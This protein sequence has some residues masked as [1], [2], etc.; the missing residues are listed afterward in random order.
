MVKCP[1]CGRDMDHRPKLRYYHCKNCDKFITE[2]QGR[3]L[4]EEERIARDRA[5]VEHREKIEGERAGW[6]LGKR[7]KFWLRG[8]VSGGKETVIEKGKHEKETV[9][10]RTEKIPKEFATAIAKKTK[11]KVTAGARRV[12]GAVGRTIDRE[13]IKPTTGL[14]TAAFFGMVAGP[15]FF[16]FFNMLLNVTFVTIPLFIPTIDTLAAVSG[17]PLMLSRSYNRMIAPQAERINQDWL[18]MEHWV[19]YMMVAF[20]V[21][22]WISMIEF[23]SYQLYQGKMI[24]GFIYTAS[25]GT[26]T[27]NRSIVI[28]TLIV[29]FT[30]YSMLTMNWALA[31]F[32]DIEYCPPEIPFCQTGEEVGTKT[33]PDRSLYIDTFSLEE[34]S[35]E[36]GRTLYGMI[37][38]TN[39][40]DEDGPTLKNV[41]L[42]VYESA[43]SNVTWESEYMCNE[44]DP[45]EIKP[46]DYRDVLVE[47]P[48]TI[49]E[50]KEW[51]RKDLVV[52]VR[53]D[54]I[55]ECTKQFYIYKS[56][57]YV[58]LRSPEHVRGSGPVNLKIIFY[59]NEYSVWFEKGGISKKNDMPILMALKFENKLQGRAYITEMNIT[60]TGKEEYLL[61]RP[62]DCEGLDTREIDD[63]KKFSIDVDINLKR[64]VQAFAGIPP[65]VKWI[66]CRFE[67][68]S[69]F[70]DRSTTLTF[71]GS[72]KYEYTEKK[73]TYTYVYSKEIEE[74]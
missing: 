33:G 22:P 53:Y 62:S 16:L 13:V 19:P 63:D 3:K 18:L 74:R 7:F 57:K 37:K 12:G 24:P 59:P 31:Q 66:S 35:V 49:R 40:N 58:T 34:M 68:P 21:W 32:M 69:E 36:S 42:I 43:M 28:L 20:F 51:E 64:S 65:N 54:M 1:K 56:D 26:Y 9:V 30:N 67:P 25:R 50:G 8:K 10:Y 23:L 70:T 72:A 15:C 27:L 60:Q 44:A 11:E 45:C 2:I 17:R 48:L 61:E 29:L 4:E 6:G 39:K 5:L 41:R 73:S 46:K 55:A 14:F 38:I 71:Y 47:I 52:Q